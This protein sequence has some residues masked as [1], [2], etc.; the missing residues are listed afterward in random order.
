MKSILLERICKALNT[1]GGVIHDYNRAYI[2]GRTSFGNW[3]PLCPKD[4]VIVIGLNPLD[5]MLAEQNLLSQDEIRQRERAY[6]FPRQEYERAWQYLER[7]GM[8]LFMK[9]SGR[10]IDVDKVLAK[11]LEAICK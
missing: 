2:I 8:F 1:Q 11:Y 6:I 7:G 5:A 4:S 10:E 9:V 3:H